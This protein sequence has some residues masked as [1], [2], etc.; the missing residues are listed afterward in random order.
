MFHGG[1][2]SGVRQILVTCFM[3]SPTGELV[4]S[5]PTLSK[6]ELH[7]W[8]PLSVPSPIPGAQAERAYWLKDKPEC[9]GERAGEFQGEEEGD[10]Y[11]KNT[12]GILFM[13][14]QVFFFLLIRKKTALLKN[15]EKP[16]SMLC[17]II[18]KA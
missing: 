17:L 6:P 13:K 4:H 8:I 7:L 18:I 2:R 15:T 16:T 9:V 3:V 1:P 14:W 12:A 5:K 11:R 10:I